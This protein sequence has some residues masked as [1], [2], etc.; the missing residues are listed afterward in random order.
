MKKLILS[1]LMT[2]TLGSAQATPI[3]NLFEL[4][5]R[6]GQT[7][8]YDAVGQ[9]NIGVSVGNEA[10]ALAMY[11]A[12]Q[13]GNPHMA[14][15]VE[16]YADES[17][18]RTHTASP[19]YKEFLR[20]SPDILTDHK[21]KIALVP[22]YLADKKVEQTPT[23]INNLVIV[24]VKPGQND[25]F[26]AVVM[27]E[28][29]QSMRVENGV[30]A[31]YA[32]TA[33]DAPNRWYFYEIYADDAAYQ[34]HRA[35]PHFK[36]YLE[37]TADMLAD[38][39]AIAI[40]PTL[41]AN[42]GGLDYTARPHHAGKPPSGVNTVP[43]KRDD[44]THYTNPPEKTMHWQPDTLAAIDRADDLKIAPYHPDM[45]TTGTP[46]WIWEVV[47]DGRLYVRA[48]S[49]PRSRWYQAA[50]KQQA[51]EIHAAGAVHRVRFAAVNDAAL[52]DKIDAAYRAKYP[53]SPYTATMIRSPARDATVEITPAVLHAN[54][55]E[56]P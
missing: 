8:A 18:Y 23:T 14:Y 29:A 19:Q 50:I 46:T 16:I 3:F 44:H 28:M 12:K 37:K 9:T 56:K 35:T 49:G 43:A 11:S 13:K 26:R 17:A 47:V 25:A 39:Q 32:A 1:A 7:T 22:Q 45:T 53:T 6:P 24:D 10:G 54:P 30:R 33:K 51:G 15:M 27:P 42:K 48:Y 40:I 34:S 31:I 52:Q 20:R 38:K 4:G 21:K 5:I 2:L 55:K 36:D 41:L